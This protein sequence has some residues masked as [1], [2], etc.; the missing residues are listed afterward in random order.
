M[1]LKSDFQNLSKNL[2]TNVFA[3]IALPI[4]VVINEAVYDEEYGDV[5][6]EDE[7]YTYTAIVGPWISDQ[8][9]TED[10][11]VG[12]LRVVVP[13]LDII[14]AP[15]TQVDT[16]IVRNETYDIINVALD[17]AESTYIIQ[18]RLRN[19]TSNRNF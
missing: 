11:E 3:D 2:I 18:V 1:G 13:F 6:V 4:T 10:I 12:D 17:A 16:I 9:N 8:E 15:T 7:E 14:V 5:L 19:V